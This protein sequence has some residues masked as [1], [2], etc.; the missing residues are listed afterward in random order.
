[1]R[2]KRLLTAM[3]CGLLLTGQAAANV[4]VETPMQAPAIVSWMASD[5]VLYQDFSQYAKRQC[6][7][8]GWDGF[9]S[10]EQPVYFCIYRKNKSPVLHGQPPVLVACPPRYANPFYASNT[11]TYHCT[12]LAIKDGICPATRENDGTF[13]IPDSDPDCAQGCSAIERVLAQ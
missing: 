13:S 8:G 12:R 10:A 2:N 7:L 5:G 6:A 11:K 3:A 9:H 1:M 4:C